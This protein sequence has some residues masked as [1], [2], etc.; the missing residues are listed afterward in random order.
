[1]AR[2]LELVTLDE[3]EKRHALRNP[4]KHD[5]QGLRASISRHGFVEVP[6]IDERTGRLV[7][8]HGRLSDIA[9]RRD[10][11]EDPPDGVEL[12]DDG[13]W[14]VPV[15]RGWAS[16]SNAD[17]E[18]YVVTSNRVGEGR[19]DDDMLATMLSD[20]RS[21]PEWLIGTGFGE[22]DVD[23]LLGKGQE[24]ELEAVEFLARRG[25]PDDDERIELIF[26]VRSGDRPVILAALDKLR[27]D[28]G[29]VDHSAA[30]VT[31]CREVEALS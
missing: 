16:N 14:L 13:T 23:K 3:L 28:R 7:A 19:W 18:A 1:M 26:S 15:L 4:R 25:E 20:Y 17:A 27:N 31:L 21:D 12:A 5:R 6:T 22:D 24:E 9:D 11:G 8:G 30:L 29:L 10:A 2:W